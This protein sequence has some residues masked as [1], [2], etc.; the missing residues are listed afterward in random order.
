MV[1]LG[2]IIS[3][4]K[5]GKALDA[6]IEKIQTSIKDSEH[7]KLKSVRHLELIQNA[8]E[9]LPKKL[10]DLQQDFCIKTVGLTERI[11]LAT[12]LTIKTINEN[13]DKSVEVE[14][15]KLSQDMTQTVINNSVNEAVSKIKQDLSQN[16]D[17]HYQFINESLEE[18]NKAEI[19]E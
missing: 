15:K 1:I 11:D 12:D 18:L 8:M 4:I 16:P 6:G 7:Q 14:E 17:M 13:I 3:K 2:W 10:E 9:R 19:N 5:I